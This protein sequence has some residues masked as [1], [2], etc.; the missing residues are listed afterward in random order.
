VNGIHDLGGMHGF[1][2][3]EH[4]PAERGFHAPWEPHVA[5]CV[6]A[7]TAWPLCTIDEFRHARERLEPTRYLTDGYFEQWLETLCRLLVEKGVVAQEELEARTSFFRANPGADPSAAVTPR[8]PLPRAGVAEASFRRPIA[9]APRFAAG[10]AVVTR[11]VHPPGHT[12]LPRYAR[13]K[14]GVVDRAH[15]AWVF[16]DTNAHGGGEHPQHVYSVRFDAR[17]L[18]GGSAEPRQ[19]VYLDCWESYLDPA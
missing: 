8:E 13:G 10:D 5:A 7:A 3:V 4:D 11:N 17:E 14:R 12:R 16:A 9:A 18:W 1:G 6:F 2:P 19:A 15:G